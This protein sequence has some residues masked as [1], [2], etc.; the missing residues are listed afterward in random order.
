MTPLTRRIFDIYP[1][2]DLRRGQVVRLIEGDPDRQTTY[3]HDPAQIARKW[4]QEGAAW[5]HVVN[6]DGAFGEQSR[7]NIAALAAILDVTH[8]YNVKVQFGGGL[9]SQS[10]VE[11][12][13]KKGV[14]RVILGTMAATRQD[15]VKQIVHIH[16]S[17]RIAAGIDARHDE[18]FT[19]G[20]TAGS[21]LSPIEFGRQLYGLGIRWTIFTDINRDGLETGVNISASRQLAESTGLNII[22]SGGVHALTEIES[23]AAGGLAGIIVGKALYENRFTLQEALVT[24]QTDKDSG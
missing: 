13:L 9:R 12:L 8:K 20:W 24:S 18:V 17:E 21:G 4:C 22:A 11:D 19:H 5:L 2:I 14:N 10:D 6:L 16:G 23:A 15:L 1:A 3:Y 7:A